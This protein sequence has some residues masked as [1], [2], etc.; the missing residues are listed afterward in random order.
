MGNSSL[1]SPI[2]RFGLCVFACVFLLSAPVSGYFLTQI[3]LE[4]RT[5]ASWP[6]VTGTLTRAKV[7]ERGF[8]RYFANVA[9]TY[10]VGSQEFTGSKIRASD[11]ECNIRDGAVQAIRGLTVGQTVTVF[12]NPSNPRQAMLQVGAGFQEY[13]MLFIPVLM[14]SIGV[15]FVVLFWLSWRRRRI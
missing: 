8:R 11:G 1:R 12:Y 9:Y 2:V 5:S 4:A 6:S 14:F 15:L 13:A 7:G 10:R 3:F